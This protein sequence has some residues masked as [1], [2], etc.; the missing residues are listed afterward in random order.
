MRDT[1]AVADDEQPDRDDTPE[2]PLATP[3][4]VVL[5]PMIALATS[6]HASPGV[7]ALLL[8]SGVSSATGIPTGWQVVTDPHE[9]PEAPAKLESP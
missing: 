2:V 1:G 9:L 3:P 7:Y 4:G 6:A 8:G 5:D